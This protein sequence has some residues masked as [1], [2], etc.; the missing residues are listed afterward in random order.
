MEKFHNLDKRVN[1]IDKKVNNDDFS[2][3]TSFN[4]AYKIDKINNKINNNVLFKRKTRSRSNSLDL[5]N[6]KKNK[7]NIKIERVSSTDTSFKEH[8]K[9]R[10]E[11]ENATPNRNKLNKYNS[12]KNIKIR[13]TTVNKSPIIKKINRSKSPVVIRKKEKNIINDRMEKLEKM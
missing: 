4:D 9:L 2:R 8:K 5:G 1:K 13:T 3:N 12:E 7:K 11:L 10:E 6:K